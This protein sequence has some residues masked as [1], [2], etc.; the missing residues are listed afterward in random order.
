MLWN[1]SSRCHQIEVGIRET[2]LPETSP[3]SVASSSSESSSRAALIGFVLGWLIMLAVILPAELDRWRDVE[4]DAI[5]WLF[6]WNV[7]STP[8]L[9][10][11]I[12]AP[13]CWKIRR[14][15]LDRSSPGVS[16]LVAWMSEGPAERNTPPV[17]KRQRFWRAWCLA[18]LVGLAGF[19]SCVRVASTVVSK[20]PGLT[21]GE[22]P[23]ALH[24]EFSYLFQAETFR[25]GQ[26]YFQ[27][28]PFEPR[29]FDQ[30]H[31]LNEGQFASRYFPGTGLWMAP[32]VTIGNPWLGHWLATALICMLVFGI[33]RELSC[34]GVGLLAGLL[35]ALSPGLVL[36]GN[37][38]LAHQPAL[39]GLTIVIY[40]FLRMT[41]VLVEGIQDEAS[42]KEL[43]VQERIGGLDWFG[44]KPTD[45]SCVSGYA[46]AFAMLCRPMTAAGVALP[47]G[48]WL[49]AWLIGNGKKSRRLT[50]A[51]LTGYGVPL[52]FGFGI[53]LVHNKLI[54]GD[55]FTTPYQLYTEMFTPRHMYGFDNVVRAEPFLV[56]NADRILRHYDRWAE[57]LDAE[58]AVKNV[59]MRFLASWQWTLGLSALVVSSF[60][61]LVAARGR[62]IPGGAREDSSAG[63]L[64]ARWWLVP[65]SIVT[66]HLAHVPYWYDGILHWHYV[67]ESGVLWCLVAAAATLIL[68][69]TFRAMQRP[70]MSLWWGAV[71]LISV[72]VNNFAVSPFWTISRLDAGIS[73]FAFARMKQFSIRSLVEET[74]TETPALV[75]IRHDP[76]DRHNDYVSNHPSLT[77][78]ILY[79]RLPIDEAAGTT[80]LSDKETRVVRSV[81]RCFPD[82]SVYVLDAVNGRVEQVSSR[83]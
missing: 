64:A 49:L 81:V 66:L 24:D 4:G 33:G 14:P 10:L 56:D 63:Q 36:F 51:I 76:N 27:S 60:V 75:L 55:A 29:V 19:L 82:R 43:P 67:F 48:I 80:R 28:D 78:P 17:E 9:F 54:T 79:G 52:L 41:R 74:V 32:F 72:T 16:L 39:L 59:G 69:R 62:L 18:F 40:A 73:E 22:L 83:K 37:L 38:L 50:M 6:D 65:A 35:A 3:D 57:N 46:L 20:E 42:S 47:F 23:P 34:S 31:V 25:A 21:L 11:L 44:V 12:V 61:F 77:G 2:S 30:M 7:D 70:G 71:L 8:F 1:K 15:L 58:L 68:I 45:W 5:A 26:W 53:I 13:L